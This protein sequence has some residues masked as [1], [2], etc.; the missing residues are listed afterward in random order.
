M[1]VDLTV[2]GGTSAGND[3]F[4][5]D[6]ALDSEVYTG[7]VANSTVDFAGTVIG[8]GAANDSA[9]Q[10]SEIDLVMA[11]GYTAQSDAAIGASILNAAADTDAAMSTYATADITAGNNVEAQTITISGQA[12]TS[13]DIDE[14]ADAKSIAALV[15]ARAD[16]TG[17]FAT[18]RTEATLSGLDTDGVVSMVLNDVKVSANVTT[19]DIS[20]LAEAINDKTGATGIVAIISNDKQSIELQHD[21]G[22][23]IT[24]SAFDSSSAVDGV[25]GT[26]VAMT[27]SGGAGTTDVVLQNGGVNAGT[28]DS[29]V[30][31]GEVEFKS[32]AGYFSVESNLA[33]GTGGLFSGSTNELQASVTETVDTIEI[34]NVEGANRSIDITDGALARVDAIRAELGAVQNRFETTITNLQTSSENLSAARSR[35]QDTD[36]AAETAS[37]T[38]SQILQQAGVAMLAQANQVPQL[39]LSLLQG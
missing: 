13:I 26:E 28:R 14:N 22:D 2:S 37:L 9:I 8:E 27:L 38:R 5:F 29:T 18:A 36:F 3:T 23:N 32:T 31:G 1:G 16:S 25:G 10:V 4:V 35:I 19:E 6:N 33:E 11:D 24:I 17:V 15:S 34:S 21:T 39:V 30:I 12:E 7:T 20:T